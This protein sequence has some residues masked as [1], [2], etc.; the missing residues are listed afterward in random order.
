LN[1]NLIIE[2]LEDELYALEDRKVVGKSRS[3]LAVKTEDDN[4]FRNVLLELI[5]GLKAL[6]RGEVLPI[7]VPERVRTRG[8]AATARNYR[9]TAV[10]AVAALREAG[11]SSEKAMEFV[12][13]A[14]GVTPEAVRKW[15]RDDGWSQ[16]SASGATGHRRVF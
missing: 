6:K 12:A 15:R 16:A 1:R 7:F 14:H 3:E 11:Y 2:I 9:L 8:K 10:G 4:I 13:D 5:E